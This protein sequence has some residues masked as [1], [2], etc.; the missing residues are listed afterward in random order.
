MAEPDDVAVEDD[1]A[2][3]AD[4]PEPHPVEAKP[5]RTREPASRK[6]ATTTRRM[7]SRKK[8]EA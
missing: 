5:K 4:L 7:T 3:P 2:Q 6:A 8:K 1:D